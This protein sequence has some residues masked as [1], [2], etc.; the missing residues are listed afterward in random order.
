MWPI[1]ERM[2]HV[3]FQPSVCENG[4]V[5]CRV[6]SVNC[7]RTHVH[8]ELTGTMDSTPPFQLSNT[9]MLKHHSHTHIIL[10]QS[11]LLSLYIYTPKCICFYKVRHRVSFNEYL[12]YVVYFRG[13][14]VRSER[15]SSFC[16]LLPQSAS[17][18]RDVGYPLIWGLLLF[19]LFLLGFVLAQVQ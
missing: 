3:S 12:L 15:V 7:A 4:S 16:S 11:T 8:C 14:S 10:T 5:L 6:R 17:Q 13:L 1:D 18:F 19:I 9:N 2:F